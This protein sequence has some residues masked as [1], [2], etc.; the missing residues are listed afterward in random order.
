PSAAG[1]YT[2]KVNTTFDGI[3]GENSVNLTVADFTPPIV[4]ATLNKSLS[5]ITINDIINLTANA[6][7]ETGLSFGQIIVNDTGEKR[8]F[9]FSLSGTAAS[10]SQNITIN[11]TRGSVINFTARANDTSNN[12]KTNDTIITVANSI[13]SGLTILYPANNFYTNAIPVPLN[14]TFTKDKDDDAITINYY[15][16][17]TLN[18]STN[19]NITFNATDDTYILSVSITDGIE[20]SAN[21]TINFTIDSVLPIINGTLNKSYNLIYLND[22]INAT[23]NASDNVSLSF[24][25]II[26]NDTGEKRFFNFSLSNANLAQF[27]QNITI[28][29]TVG[30]AINI[31]GRV[32]D[33]SNNFKQNETIITVAD[34]IIPIANSS[35]NKSLS[36]ITINDIINLTA[37]ATD[38]TGLSFGQIIVN[39]SGFKRYFN[40]SLSGTS[41]KF[42]QNV[43]INVSRGEV[44]NFTVRVNDT[45]NN[46]KTNDTIIT[47]ANTPPREFS[48][49]SPTLNHYFNSK[50]IPF[51]VTFKAD[52]DSD[53]ITINYYV[54]GK[55]N[56]S[57]ALNTTFNASDGYYLLNVSIT[58]S[59][60]H[61]DNITVNFT[62]D[63]IAPI[64]NATLN[65]SSS[66]KG[67][68]VINIT[69]N[70]TDDI[71]LGLGQIAIND[72][73][74]V[75]Y[76]NF[77]LSRGATATFSQNITLHGIGMVNFTAKVFDLAN[78]TDTNDT[79]LEV[80]NTPPQGLSILQP[81]NNHYFNAIPLPLN[82]TFTEDVEG[83]AITIYYYINSLLNQTSSVN[84]TLNASDGYYI[85][86]V[87]LYDTIDFSANSTVNF[88]I[89]RISPTVLLN[90]PENNTLSPASFTPI[91]T[92]LDRNL[93]N[94]TLY[95]NFTGTWR[96]NITMQNAINATQNTFS[97]VTLNDSTFVWDVSCND[98]AGNSAFNS[99]NFT[100]TIDA[101]PPKAN[102]SLNKS[103]A[104]ITIN[105]IINIT[106][107]ITDA[108]GLSIA[109]AI[110]NI[111]GF[112]RY[113][114]FS[115]SG[116]SAQISQNVT[117]NVSRGEVINFTV[118]VN[119]TVNNF[120][121]NDTII[122]VANRLPTDLSILY[123]TNN[124]FTNATALNLNVTFS[125]DADN[126]AI[127]INYYINGRLN[128]STARNTTFNAT[129][130]TY[131]LNVS[132]T[133]GFDHSANQTITFT[134]DR[135]AP[136]SLILNITPNPAEFGTENVS[137]NFTASDTNLNATYVNVSYP[138]GTFFAQYT[139]NT[140]LTTINL[141]IIGNYTILLFA[142]DSA[143]NFNTTS[144]ELKV[145][146]TTAPS[147]FDLSTPTDGTRSTNF[148]PNLDWQDTFEPNFANYTIEIST[149][150]AFSYLNYTFKAGGNSSNS[151]F[152]L[153]SSLAPFI[154]WTWRVIAYDKQNQ[155]RI[156]TSAFRYETFQNT[157]PTAFNITLPSNNSLKL[158]DNINFTWNA[159]TDIDND[160]ITYELL[161]A[162]DASFTNIDLNRTA[163]KTTHLD[164]KQN[165]SSLG[166]GTRYWK[167]R[168]YD[169]SNYSNYSDYYELKSIAAALNITAPTNDSK[170]Y[171]ANTTEIAISEINGTD[172][173]SNVTIQLNNT[174]YTASNTSNTWHVNVSFSSLTAQYLNVTAYGFN[175]TNNLTTT[176][177]MQIILS[178][179]ATS[180]TISY[181]C[182]NETYS[183]NST[184]V[185]I[186]LK[187]SLDTLIN[188]TNATIINPSG[189]ITILNLTSFTKDSLIYTHN[190]LHFLNET[191]NYTL[192][193]TVLDIEGKTYNKSSVFYAVTAVKT[194]NVTGINLT[195]IG[196]LDVCSANSIRN[197]TVIVTN[198]PENSSYDV[199]IRTEKPTVI[200][201][202]LN[203]TNTTNI[204]NYTNLARNISAPSGQRIVTEFEIKTNVTQFSNITVSYNYTSLESSLDDET[205]LRMYKCDSQSS[206]SFTQLSTTLNTTLNIISAVV[207]S[208]SVFLVSETATTTTTETVTTTVSSGGGG[209]GGGGAG[210]GSIITKVASLD[211]IVPSPLTVRTNDSI[212]LPLLLKNSGDVNLNNITLSHEISR[213][214]ITLE[215]ANTFFSSLNINET[216]STSAI[217]KTNLQPSNE[218]RNEIKIIANV[219]TP[220]L[221]ESVT[222]FLD[223]IDVYK[224]NRTVIQEKLKFTLDLFEQNP[225]CLELKELLKQAES[226]LEKKEF[227]KSIALIE[228]AINACRQL[229][230][231]KGLKPV[232]PKP[233]KKV[234]FKISMPLLIFILIMLLALVIYGISRIKWKLP[235]FSFSLSKKHHK[236]KI[237]PTKKEVKSLEDEEKE[238]RKM[239][240]RR[241]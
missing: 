120:Y 159:S 7:D 38:E 164:L 187:S 36:N 207:N 160:N 77:T 186:S 74:L 183:L 212:T 87:S 211:I 168:A 45:S 93:G 199:E 49:L 193:S 11:T 228:S 218:T 202:K 195:S 81:I 145:Q 110:V 85:L 141:T 174:N 171:P 201:N 239:L 95:F 240:R 191:G 92:P 158:Y 237:G 67:N 204:L 28:S 155:S 88:T 30:C 224:G 146:D 196:F 167:V 76:F 98:L 104:N 70:A 90:S 241:L 225:E 219:K 44:I 122:T 128:D 144:I 217:I 132:I 136:S 60:A 69:A 227:Q 51:N 20:H 173:I 179:A 213:E 112:K 232:L 184:N 18:V 226:S 13:P 84:T 31:T 83:Q 154:N 177:Y 190:Y 166:D 17:G 194:I 131:I 79:I 108:K 208:L 117:I 72:S 165:A 126:D 43:T 116:T 89:D 105:D 209:G 135:T 151:S 27:S 63:T 59:V 24:G 15:I 235:K 198:V 182:S 114:N 61:H 71:G 10:F 58:D 234:G 35:L 163:I 215:I 138:N 100:V 29:C 53:A 129:D 233:A 55:L 121:T 180:P 222:V 216:V 94:C 23:F 62:L 205:G 82:V 115:L 34:N 2:I 137:V 14:I 37:N 125:A 80:T 86:N 170:F 123:P 203:L 149:S 46:F 189:I 96:S 68:D 48:V 236:K 39:I 32:N 47:V 97:A 124:L 200:I 6:T 148:T 50:P 106:A 40:F 118:R 41:D 161:V 75:R 238:L 130:G 101:T 33:T 230:G 206:C 54:N 221:T 102:T 153:T 220:K 192:N 16:N 5:N 103:L 231:D 176:A 214:G 99:S 134:I 169:G 91:I 66:I 52:A 181:I 152:M 133:D 140:T 127:T 223:A 210:G 197:G 143:G 150:S 8:Y 22:I 172:W 107:N 109:Q 111:S 56:D 4:N 9:N 25:Q 65:K 229:V 3:Y 147:A 78:N 12:F 73:G 1:T 156:S 21:Q 42:S 185:T 64:V 178:K 157:P 162:K 26:V 188:S 119:D 175:S 57:T 142:N 139:Q 19:T 113:F